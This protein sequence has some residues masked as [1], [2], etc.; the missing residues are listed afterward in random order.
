MALMDIGFF[1]EGGF[2]SNYLA[3]YIKWQKM[4]EESF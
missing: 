3:S 4:T 1:S 2:G